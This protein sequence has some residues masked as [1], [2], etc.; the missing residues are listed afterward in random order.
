MD[1]GMQCGC[2]VDL[3]GCRSE[4]WLQGDLQESA[5]EADPSDMDSDPRMA[6]T[7]NLLRHKAG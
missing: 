6:F 7:Q 5:Q 3:S 2:R 1:A 4:V